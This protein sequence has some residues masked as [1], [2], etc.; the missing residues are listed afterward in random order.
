MHTGKRHHI[1]YMHA[2][3]YTKVI[4]FQEYKNSLMYTCTSIHAKHV[5]IYPHDN[6]RMM[7]M[8]MMMMKKKKKKIMHFYEYKHESA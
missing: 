8:M 4:S 6:T 5:T 1:G 7:M 3:I 2:H